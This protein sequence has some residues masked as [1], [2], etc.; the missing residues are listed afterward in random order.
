MRPMNPWLLA[1]A[2]ALASTTCAVAARLQPL[3]AAAIQ[4]FG[5]WGADEYA[6]QFKDR[7]VTF[8]V[9][10]D[11]GVGF[12]E[13]ADGIMALPAKDLSEEGVSKA[14]ASQVGAPLC[15]LS[16]SQ[17]YQ[18]LVNGKPVGREKFDHLRSVSVDG[19]EHE[20]TIVLCTIRQAAGG[21]R[22]VWF[23]G[24][25]KEP[26]FKATLKKS[27]LA[28]RR[29]RGAGGSAGLGLIPMS[30]GKD[31]L[32]LNITLFAKYAAEVELSC[33]APISPN[34]IPAT[35]N[36]PPDTGEDA[37]RKKPA[38]AH[39]SKR[40]TDFGSI[41]FAMERT[42]YLADGKKLPKEPR[43]LWRY[44]ANPDGAEVMIG[45]PIVHQGVVYFGDA[46]GAMHALSAESG[47]EQWTRNYGEDRIIAAPT[48]AEGQLYFESAGGVKCLSLDGKT[49]IWTRDLPK[50]AG[51]TWPLVVGDAV[52]AAGG[53]GLIYALKKQDGTLLWS[54]DVVADR[55]RD[56]RGFDSGFLLRP[57]FRARIQSSASDGDTLY[58]NVLDQSR[59]FALDCKTGARRW[60]YRAHAWLYSHPVIADNYVLAGSEDL[61]LHCLDRASGKL[62]WKT[63]TGG[64]VAS[65]PA[66]L[67][68][69]VYVP[70]CNGRVL[71]LD[72][73]T[74]RQIWSHRQDP[75][76]DA[77]RFCY[78]AP[79]VTDDAV[80]V[81][82]SNGE[83]YSLDASS[84]EARWGMF[85]VN[86]SELAT[87]NMATDGKRL[88]VVTRNRPYR[89]PLRRFSLFA[90]GD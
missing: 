14:A 85:V 42:G 44:P 89:P 4:Q 2:L 84:G 33:V 52:F 64:I 80:Y 55:P 25:D 65:A 61:C 71:C 81:A 50:S 67:N 7:P 54:A 70:V 32:V 90:V 73:E 77:N 62:A 10:V 6:R 27:D 45:D 58:Q 17:R 23:Y 56:L 69:R 38:V 82:A 88:F 76:F 1:G 8:P 87:Y 47:N 30:L 60:T 3:S 15:H 19:L 5:G 46:D 48:I 41:Q 18:F 68:G 83:V 36:T 53:D 79:I 51:D 75:P 26:I 39:V 11:N 49:V 78:C 31:K 72:L 28:A 12:Y 34:G 66:V 40:S 21:D 22:E 9:D 24:K 86:N 43:I 57:D 20:T 16:F 59:M 13:G 74:G 63:M 29:F 37:L 35:T